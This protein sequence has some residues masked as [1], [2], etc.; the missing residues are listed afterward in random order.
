MPNG[1]MS[2]LFF[3]SFSL[4]Q[5]DR[6]KSLRK[7]NFFLLKFIF[8]LVYFSKWQNKMLITLLAEAN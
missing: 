2:F 4:F 8:D 3:P 6:K 7:K 1:N 5:F